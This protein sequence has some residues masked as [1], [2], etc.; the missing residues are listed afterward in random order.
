MLSFSRKPL[1]WLPLNISD[2]TLWIFDSYKSFVMTRLGR[3]TLPMI[4]YLNNR[5]KIKQTLMFVLLKRLTPSH[6][7]GIHSS[8]VCQWCS[9]SSGGRGPPQEDW[10]N[11]TPVYCT[12]MKNVA[13]FKNPVTVRLV[14]FL[15]GRKR[16]NVDFGKFAFRDT[17]KAFVMIIY[18]HLLIH[19]HFFLPFT[20]M[21][22]CPQHV[23]ALKENKN[24]KLIN[25]PAYHLAGIP[26]VWWSP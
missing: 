18:S 15:L 8:S 2:L 5:N 24:L 9:W 22:L 17:S 23:K 14:I 7:Q 16:F 11:S 26:A 25:I 3:Y 20:F 4:V 6:A 13:V 1:W 19:S 12:T 21:P 10:R